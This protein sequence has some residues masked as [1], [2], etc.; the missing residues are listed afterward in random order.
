MYMEMKR[1]KKRL[2]IACTLAC[3]KDST[4]KYLDTRASPSRN[5]SST[6]SDQAHL[7]ICLMNA[8]SGDEELRSECNDMAVLAG[9]LEVALQQRSMIERT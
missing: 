1:E 6:S 4:A 9:Y 7:G 5:V 8:S 2:L 3:E